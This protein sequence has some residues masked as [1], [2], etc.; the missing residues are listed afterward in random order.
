VT[1]RNAA[2]AF[3]KTGRN[4]V[5]AFRKTGRGVARSLVPRAA[6]MPSVAFRRCVGEPTEV[7]PVLPLRRRVSFPLTNQL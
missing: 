1:R 7:Y 4:A 6:T 3:R 2:E 5:K